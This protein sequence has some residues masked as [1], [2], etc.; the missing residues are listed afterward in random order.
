MFQYKV[1]YTGHVSPVQSLMSA[2]LTWY[3]VYTLWITALRFLT[4]RLFPPHA[5]VYLYEAGC[6]RDLSVEVLLSLLLLDFQGKPR[7]Q[8]TLIRKNKVGLYRRKH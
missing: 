6:S 4:L 5:K 2:R 7:T 8:N 3:L 1:C